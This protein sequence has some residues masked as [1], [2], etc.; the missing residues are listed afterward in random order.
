MVRLHTA[1]LRI[2][3]NVSWNLANNLR[4]NN[5]R[6][7][8]KG[9]VRSGQR[10]QICPCDSLADSVKNFPPAINSCLKASFGHEREKTQNER[11]HETNEDLCAQRH[12]R[13]QI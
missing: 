11:E 4:A 6:S 10:G 3:N 12:L 9:H 1:N 5:L 7:G 2:M 13:K 8:Q